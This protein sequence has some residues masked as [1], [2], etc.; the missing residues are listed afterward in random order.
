MFVLSF[1]ALKFGFSFCL[2]LSWFVRLSLVFVS[3]QHTAHNAQLT[4]NSKY[5]KTKHTQS[6]NEHTIQNKKA[7]DFQSK[8]IQS[9][10]R[11]K[12]TRHSQSTRRQNQHK[13]AQE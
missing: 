5:E 6:T 1:C 4:H 7:N 3:C 13:K 9:T 12:R 10:S 8:T 11:Q 2:R